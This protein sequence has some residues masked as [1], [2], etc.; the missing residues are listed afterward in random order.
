MR[1][2]ADMT[3]SGPYTSASGARSTPGVLTQETAM[4][5][6]TVQFLS[7]I[8]VPVLARSVRT[9]LVAEDGSVERQI[10]FSGCESI[11]FL[12][13]SLQQETSSVPGFQMGLSLLHTQLAKC[14]PASV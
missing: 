1:L 14:R 8:R 4:W 9:T 2:L 7:E 10:W 5:W 6:P 12:L 13:V 3:P 11:L